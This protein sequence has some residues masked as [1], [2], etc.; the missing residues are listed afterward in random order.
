MLVGFERMVVI[1]ENVYLLGDVK[2]IFFKE[3]ELLYKLNL[4]L[5]YRGWL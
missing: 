5:I 1:E 2:K 4:D 3:I